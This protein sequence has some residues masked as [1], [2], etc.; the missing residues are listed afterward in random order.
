MRV[1]S[2]F[3]L[4]MLLLVACQSAVD[5]VPGCTYETALNYNPEATIDDGSCVFEGEENT[6]CIDGTGSV[7]YHGYD[8]SVVQIGDQCWFAENLRNSFFRNGDS[9]YDIGENTTSPVSS[10]PVTMIYGSGTTNCS[11]GVVGWDACDENLALEAF[12]RLYNWPAIHDPRS[13]CPSG[14][15]IPFEQEFLEMF[16]TVGLQDTEGVLGP[17][18]YTRTSLGFDENLGFILRSDTGWYLNYSENQFGFSA[19]PAGQRKAGGNWPYQDAGTFAG[20]WSSTSVP[21][22]EPTAI[23]YYISQYDNDVTRYEIEQTAGF[24]SARCVKD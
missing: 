19:L 15:H 22:S 2:I 9:I 18:P 17:Y 6:G 8:Y 20:W 24:F 12:G 16:V 21:A 14:W 13:I 4:S 3:V 23:A 7:F 1:L 5:D 11:S 10:S